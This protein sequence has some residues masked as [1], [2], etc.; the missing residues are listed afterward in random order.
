[1]RPGSRHAAYQP[2][3]WPVANALPPAA[4]AELDMPPTSEKVSH[5]LNAG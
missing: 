2:A 3:A 1:L 5:A 4:A